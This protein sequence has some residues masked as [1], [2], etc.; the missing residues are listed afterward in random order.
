VQP[1]ETKDFKNK[2]MKKILV[3]AFICCFAFA[4]NTNAQIKLDDILG[5]VTDLLGKKELLSV[6]KGFSPKFSLGKLQLNKVGI[7]GEQLKGIKVLGTIFN[8]KRAADITKLY[9]T[10]KTGLV[11]YKI[12]AGAGTVVSTYS[13]VR[14]A[15]A[16]AKFDDKMVKQLL[17]PALTTLVTGVVTKLLT[18]KASYK[19]VDI[20]NGVVKKKVKDIFNIG[21]SSQGVGVGLYVRL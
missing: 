6:K 11:V 10:Y 14:G 9:K 2:N 18:K 1:V 5:Q 20:F 12:L 7:L 19:A 15:T 17:V 8:G 13:A 21:A 4:N 3:I 16:E